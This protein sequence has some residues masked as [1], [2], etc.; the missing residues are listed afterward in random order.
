MTGRTG[1]G[2]P[3]LDYDSA[4][5]E[6]LCFGWVDGQAGTV[7]ERRS[8]QYFSPRRAGSPWS[9]YNK[10]RIEKLLAAGVMRAAG[11]AV[12]ERAKADGSW[13]IFD[14]VDRLELPSELEA[15][16]DARP[17]ARANWEAWPDSAKRYVLSSIVLAK[18]SET[19]TSRIDKAAGAAERND[20]PDR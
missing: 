7:D 12:I 2:L 4:V 8:K 15:A 17:N 13:S 16:L 19:R 14:S 6:A 5:Q 3:H 10:Q 11:L 1:S 9:R 18:R 20:R